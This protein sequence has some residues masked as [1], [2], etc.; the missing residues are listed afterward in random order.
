MFLDCPLSIAAMR[1]SIEGLAASLPE[2]KS[3]SLELPQL[4]PL[5]AYN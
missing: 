4:I 1:Y 3:Y 2:M 5:L